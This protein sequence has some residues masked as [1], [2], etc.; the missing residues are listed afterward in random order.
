ME[1]R[2]AMCEVAAEAEDM[3]RTLQMHPDALRKWLSAHDKA[4]NDQQQHVLFSTFAEICEFRGQM[5]LGVHICRHKDNPTT[6]GVS[7]QCQEAHC[8][9]INK[10]K[11]A[12]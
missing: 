10:K 8:P 4:A 12:A 3:T 9:F 5:L 2:R 11:D 1:F 6:N 7:G